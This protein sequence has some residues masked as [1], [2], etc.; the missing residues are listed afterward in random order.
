[1]ELLHMHVY[2]YG[3]GVVASLPRGRWRRWLVLGLVEEVEKFSVAGWGF[4]ALWFCKGQDGVGYGGMDGLWVG[5]LG[6]GDGGLEVGGRGFGDRRWEVGVC[7]LWFG[8]G[9]LGDWGWE[10]GW[11]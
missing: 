5:C 11:W 3:T 7:G 4:G 2:G 8:D 1:M 10:E 9:S 6:F